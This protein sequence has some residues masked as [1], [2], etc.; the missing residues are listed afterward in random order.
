MIGTE[1]RSK[2]FY[3]KFQYRAKIFCSGFHWTAYSKTLAH[4]MLQISNRQTITGGI[5]Q[6]SSPDVNQLGKFVD[7]RNLNKDKIMTRTEMHNGSIFSND[8]ELLKTLADIFGAVDI[9]EARVTEDPNVVT[10]N[11]PKHKFRVYL[12]SR[13]PPDGFHNEID[14]F[15]NVHKASL[16]PC[17]ALLSWIHWT[18]NPIRG[19]WTSK[20]L[21]SS[22]FIEYDDESTFTLMKL[23]LG[24]ILGKNYKVVMR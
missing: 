21:S 22:H 1:N 17:K 15:L 13:V 8:L 18:K 20:W 7:W 3:N 16:F 23:Y 2:L 19:M 11:D 5:T 6:F 14:E 24:S 10:L 9:T 4:F 12:K